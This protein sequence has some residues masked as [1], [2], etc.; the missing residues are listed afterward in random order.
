MSLNY[1]CYPKHPPSVLPQK[2]LKRSSI[3]RFPSLQQLC[4]Q[5]VRVRNACGEILGFRPDP[6]S[7]VPPSDQLV[8]RLQDGSDRTRAQIRGITTRTMSRGAECIRVRDR[9]GSC[10]MLHC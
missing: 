1:L 2:E 3:P 4:L 5:N 6:L 10:T 9:M 8:H 7:P